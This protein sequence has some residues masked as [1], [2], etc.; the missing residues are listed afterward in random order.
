MKHMKNQAVCDSKWISFLCNSKQDD[1][2]FYM[3]GANSTYQQLLYSCKVVCSFNHL[4]N[5]KADESEMFIQKRSKLETNTTMLRF[6][7]LTSKIERMAVDMF[8]C[9]ERKLMVVF[10]F[11][12]AIQKT[13]LDRQKAT[14]KSQR[15]SKIIQKRIAELKRVISGLKGQNLPKVDLVIYKRLKSLCNISKIIK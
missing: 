6:R 10:L 9:S 14:G 4:L 15:E 11:Y 2:H 8:N 3:P 13:L 1:L 7:M 5:M 12:V